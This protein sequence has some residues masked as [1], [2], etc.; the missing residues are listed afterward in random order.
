MERTQDRP[1]DVEEGGGPPV[2]TAWTLD[3]AGEEPESADLEHAAP[4]PRVGEGIELI[5]AEGSRRFLRVRDVI[6]VLQPSAS[7]RP[8]VREGDAGPNSTVAG[9]SRIGE[10]T[11]LRAGL[12]R[13]VA[14]E[15]D[16]AELRRGR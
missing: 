15:V 7:E 6:H 12:P 9:G 1:L 10:S 5:G 2:G 11:L 13:V 4:L 8:P 16:E 14:V 3:I